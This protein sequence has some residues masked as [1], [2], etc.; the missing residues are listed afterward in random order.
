VPSGASA[1]RRGRAPA[2]GNVYSRIF[3]VRGVDAGQL[4]GAE[5]AKEGRIVLQDH[6]AVGHR[7]RRGQFG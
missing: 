4:V 3:I 1:I 6:N 5:L 7:M 2:A